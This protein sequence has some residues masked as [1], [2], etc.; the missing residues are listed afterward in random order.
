M[1]PGSEPDVAMP[2]KSSGSTSPQPSSLQMTPDTND[3]TPT[4]NP[5]TRA[6]RRRKRKAD[7]ESTSTEP[8]KKVYKKRAP[9]D[10]KNKKAKP[11]QDDLSG[12]KRKRMSVA[13]LGCR[14]RKIKVCVFFYF[15]LIF[16]SYFDFL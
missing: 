9:V 15:N 7:P 12:V 14:A 6:P 11:P 3:S 16:V 8:L 1:I 5:T 2:P 4:A 13:C 10:Q